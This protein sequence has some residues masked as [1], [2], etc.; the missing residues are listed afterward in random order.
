MEDEIKG[1]V[2]FKDKK[3]SFLYSDT[4]LYLFPNKFDSYTFKE[5]VKSYEIGKVIEDIIIS[6]IT[7][8]KK[9][10]VFEVSGKYLNNEDFLTF[11][12]H[13]FYEYQAVKYSFRNKSGKDGLVERDLKI[14]GMKLR[15]LDVDIFYPPEKAFKI[16]FLTDGNFETS[17]ST[18]C[19]DDLQLG[20][21]SY[22]KKEVTFSA[23]HYITQSFF[24]ATPYLSTSEIVA[25]FSEP[26]DFKFIKTI[27]LAIDQTFRYLMRRNNITL[28]S[29]EIFDLNEKSMREK[30]GHFCYLH[31]S[32]QKETNMEMKSR[33]LLYDCVKEKFADLVKLFLDDI[34]YIEHLPANIEATNKL[35][36]DRMLLDFVAFEREYTNIY[37]E[38][39]VRSEEYKTAKA[40]AL[41]A[42]DVLL[43]QNAGKQKEY[44]ASFRKRI[45]KDENSLA[46]RLLFVI[47]DCKTILEPFLEYILGKNYDVKVEDTSALKNI[48]TI[49]NT[50]RNDMA[51][52]NFDIQFDYSHA[53]GF[54]IMEIVLYAMR[55]KMLGIE[56]KS[57]QKG[58]YQLMGFNF[59]LK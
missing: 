30:I 21:L 29:V 25:A 59:S 31:K 36:T 40:L 33:A 11:E 9:D 39:K 1:I 8:N 56:E 42:M 15:G 7:I 51:H 47:H 43:K 27:Y 57:I 23:Q 26:V 20:K 49:M 54:S 55:L 45:A 24:S 16:D 6:G 53:T 18:K 44:I 19:M 38:V 14:L 37:P 32:Q 58:I 3:Y 13:S 10:I 2:K 41:D 34:I 50:L 35:G 22:Q 28:D 4:K 12:V 52:G 48:A 46:D 17:V 5:F